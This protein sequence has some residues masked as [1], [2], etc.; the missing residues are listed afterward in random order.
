MKALGAKI[1]ADL[2]RADAADA[3]KRGDE[4]TEDQD[5]DQAIAE[6]DRAVWFDPD[7]ALAYYHR[8]MAQ[9]AVR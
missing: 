8:G 4:R 6:Y 3:V 7:N 1:K 2:D 9:G 5:Y